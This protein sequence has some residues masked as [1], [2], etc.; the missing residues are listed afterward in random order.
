MSGC[1]RR[2]EVTLP[3]ADVVTAVRI[4]AGKMAGRRWR[5]AER[6][7]SECEGES[8]RGRVWGGECEG[9]SVRGRVW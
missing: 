2:D 6:R 8:V 4:S 1:D 5:V 3:E 7:V 9:E